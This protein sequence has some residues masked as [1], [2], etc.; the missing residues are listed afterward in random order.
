MNAIFGVYLLR[1]LAEEN[2]EATL[3]VATD[4]ERVSVPDIYTEYKGT[5]ERMPDNLRSQIDGVF[6]L[7]MLWGIRALSRENDMKQMI[8]LVRLLI[9]TKTMNIRL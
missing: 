7:L 8:S 4:I 1:S 5:R 3:A 2:P 6:A 9:S